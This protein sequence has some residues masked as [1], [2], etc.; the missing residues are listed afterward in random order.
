LAD[1]DWIRLMILKNS[2]DQDWIG[3]NFNGQD[4]TW[5]K[6]FTVRSSLVAEMS[7]D[8]DWI[9]LD[10]DWSQF[11]PDQDWTRL[12]FFWNLAD[13]GWIELTKFFLYLCDYCEHIKNFSCDPILQICK[14][15]VYFAMIGKS[16]AETIL[17]FILY[18]SV[19][20]Y[21]VEATWT[22]VSSVVSVYYLLCKCSL[23]LLSP[24]ALA[25]SEVMAPSMRMLCV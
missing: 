3:F 9:G 11:W 7:T 15:G 10:Q 2:A 8:Q 5:T 22:Y 12:Q 6:K 21:Y 24:F 17:Q 1:Q 4:W 19:W 25:Q 20:T 18:S 13:Q 23:I 14:M 16:S